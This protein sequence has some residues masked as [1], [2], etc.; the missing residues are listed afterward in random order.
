MRSEKITQGS[1]FERFISQSADL[2][3]PIETLADECSNSAG[4]QFFHSSRIMFVDPFK[5]R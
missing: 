5:L 2:A 3:N 1:V 4:K